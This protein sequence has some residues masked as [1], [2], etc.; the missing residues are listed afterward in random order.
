MPTDATG[1]VLPPV[2]P[3][4]GQRPGETME[5]FFSRRQERD[6]KLREKETTTQQSSQRAREKLQASRPRPGKKGASVFYWDDVEGFRIR[7]PLPRPQVERM[8]DTWTAPQ[9][10]YNGFENCWDCCSLFGDS[11]SEAELNSDDD[12][13]DIYPTVNPQPPPT[14]PNHTTPSIQSIELQA[15]G[16][17]YFFYVCL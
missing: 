7:T 14:A 6:E 15:V 12:H 3:N 16:S 10:V 1:R 8:W 17:R 11:L 4:S 5:Q 13:E 9:K 2:I